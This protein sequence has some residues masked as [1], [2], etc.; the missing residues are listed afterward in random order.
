MN[1]EWPTDED[2]KALSEPIQ[3]PCPQPVVIEAPTIQI[4]K[5]EDTQLK[6]DVKEVITNESAVKL[7]PNSNDY[8][9]YENFNLKQINL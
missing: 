6:F 5:E 2:L 8:S 4:L 7:Y 9:Y 1:G 3:I